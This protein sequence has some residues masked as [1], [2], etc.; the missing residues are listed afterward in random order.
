MVRKRTIVD[1]SLAMLT[2]KSK[3]FLQVVEISHIKEKDIGHFN[4]NLTLKIN[5]T[6]RE[7]ILHFCLPH[8]LSDSQLSIIKGVFRK[9]VFN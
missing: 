4:Q 3:A 1:R 6:K 2:R 5:D 8:D 7:I 9:T